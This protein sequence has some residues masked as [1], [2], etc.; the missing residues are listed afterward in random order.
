MGLRQ[1][2]AALALEATHVLV[3]EAPGGWL[4]RV[5]VEREVARRGWRLA[6]S[7]ADADALVLVGAA[8]PQLRARVE[9]VWEQLP[10]PRSRVAVPSGTDAGR[11]GAALDAVA[12]EL[13]DADRQALDA[14]QRGGPNVAAMGDDDMDD[15][16]MQMAP[17]GIP[18]AEGGPDRDG[19]EMDVL[20]VPLGPVLPHWPAGLVL[21]CALQGDVVLEA[22][23][24]VLDGPHSHVDQPAPAERAARRCDQVA[25]LLALAGWAG[26]HS[27][28]VDARD[29]LLDRPDVAGGSA[30]LDGLERRLRRARLLRWSLRGIGQ[31]H[32]GEDGI[33]VPEHLDGDV[34]AR[35]WQLLDRART[36]LTGDAVPEVSLPDVLATAERLVAGL[37]LAAARL[38]LASLAID[39][40][41]RGIPA[42][43]IVEVAPDA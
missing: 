5:T 29:V 8:G 28:A 3:V 9:V 1:R 6:V 16:E 15:D 22:G 39:T 11:V 38:V 27:A 12:A 17:S 31:L 36:E 25:D 34:P 7:A 32:S 26:E 20:H 42:G 30:L 13:L 40:A 2:L 10:G 23:A 33:E 35:L 18:L 19:L 24:S 14:R 41:P 37:D 4:A 43:R 21:R